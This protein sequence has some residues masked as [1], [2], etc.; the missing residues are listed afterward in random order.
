MLGIPDAET[1]RRQPSLLWPRWLFLRLLGFG[2]LTGFLSLAPQ[3]RGLIGP[4]GILPARQLLG[5]V[6]AIH[7]GAGRYLQV[8][9]LLWLDCG[10]SA[11]SGL[12]WAGALASALLILNLVPRLA[13]LLCWGLYLSFVAAARQ[14]SG[15][16]S[17]GLLL[18]TAL[19]AFFLAPRGLRPGLG[20]ADPPAP[21]AMFLAHWLL[22]RLMFGA[23]SEKVFGGDP[24]WTGFTALDDYFENCP[25]PT[26]I[27]WW[28]QHLPHAF[29]VAGVA[30][31]LAVEVFCPFLIWFG[32]G[33]RLVACA[34]WTVLQTG[35][36]LTGNY[37]FLNGNALALGVL[38]LD[39]AAVSRLVRV[40]VPASPDLPVR[41]GWRRAAELAAEI[42]V[43]YVSVLLFLRG[44]GLPEASLPAVLA[45]PARAVASFRSVNRYAL[46]AVM[47][48]DRRQIEIEGSADGGRTWRPYR[49]R[50]QPQDSAQPPPFMAPHLPRLDWNLWFAA[51]GRAEDWSLVLYAGVRLMENEPSVLAL[52]AG[53]PFPDG[54]PT[55]IRFPLMQG[56]FTDLET[57][58]RTGLYWSWRRVGEYAPVLARDPVSGKVH[59]RRAAGEDGS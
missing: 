2:F 52:F 45:G 17:D 16:Q 51:L 8:P 29:Q 38:L 54:P 14:F 4:Q 50:W 32:R 18:E 22:F 15:F 5:A 35:I 7:P 21:F 24:G 28:A 36:L 23:G 6:A 13:L 58:R 12:C 43:F 37:A 26:W 42:F 11:L 47:T 49:F 30:F 48:H 59:L 3:I 25:F 55:Q 1:E 56:R 39:D 31:T 10:P 57:W 53:N 34:L 46:F 33:P 40:R 27:G 20:A 19:V 41:P 44:L 9:S